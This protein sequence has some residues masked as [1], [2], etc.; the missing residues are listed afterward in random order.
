M[1]RPVRGFRGLAHEVYGAGC[2]M[3]PAAPAKPATAFTGKH[4]RH[5]F[6]ASLD[7]DR[8]RDRRDRDRD[9]ARHGDSLGADRETDTE[10]DRETDRNKQ[11]DYRRTDRQ[12][13]RQADRQTCIHSLQQSHP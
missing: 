2:K 1:P 7:R 12:A 4:F 13:D 10:T 8:Q 5:L 11:R 6:A 3:F 9:E